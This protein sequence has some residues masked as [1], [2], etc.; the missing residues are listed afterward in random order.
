MTW[1]EIIPNLKEKHAEIRNQINDIKSK[2]IIYPNQN[3][4]LA[5]SEEVCPFSEIK[6]LVIAPCTT[7]DQ[8]SDI[9]AFSNSKGLIPQDS[10]LW[11]L[12]K[13]VHKSLY[14]YV[15]EDKFDVLFKSG[16]LRP[17]AKQGM[18]LINNAPTRE[19]KVVHTELWQPFMEDIY[20]TIAEHREIL[21]VI[22]YGKS[23]FHLEKYFTKKYHKVFKVEIN[24]IEKSKVFADAYIWIDNSTENYFTESQKVESIFKKINLHLHEFIDME[25]FMKALKTMIMDN[26]FPYVDAKNDIKT[27][28]EEIKKYLTLE[29]RQFFNL[30]LK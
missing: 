6:Q 11:Q 22:L 19:E 7:A 20:K 12:L 30:T 23:T 3:P 21:A 13:S 10:K 28:N 15:H 29:F 16:N 27:W 2:R 9:L 5:F 26:N 17:W 18:M 25:L 8:Y 4:F 24:E 1:N 14:E